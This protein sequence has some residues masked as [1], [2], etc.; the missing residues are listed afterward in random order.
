MSARFTR[1]T[2]SFLLT[3]TTSASPVTTFTTSCLL[4]RTCAPFSTTSAPAVTKLRREFFEWLDGAGNVFKQ[5]PRQGQTNYLGGYDLKT[6]E[7][8]DSARTSKIPFPL[9][10]VFVATPVVSDELATEVYRRVVE[11]GKSVRAVSAELN[12]TLERVAAIVRLKAIEKKWVSE[13]KPVKPFL[14]KAI[15]SMLI[16]TPAPTSNFSS[17]HEP[18]NDIPSHPHTHVQNFVPVS[19]SRAFTR[20]DAGAAFGLPSADELIP[21]PEL[22]TAAAEAASGIGHSEQRSNAQARD[23]EEMEKRNKKSSLKQAKAASKETVLEN[24]RWRW[25]IQDAEAG[26]VG[27]RYGVPHEDRKRGQIKIPTRVD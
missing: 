11:G 20:A 7:P 14:R 10:P 23:T 21:H 4:R 27:F 25:R 19:E 9:N 18:I 3:T 12:V 15:H 5:P 13:K 22:I 16:T 1:P 24:G 17:A 2:P 6:G 26:K 8:R